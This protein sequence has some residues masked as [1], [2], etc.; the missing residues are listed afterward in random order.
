MENDSRG[1][2]TLDEDHF[3][4]LIP[5]CVE[6]AHAEDLPDAVRGRVAQQ[7]VAVVVGEDWGLFDPEQ[8][9]A[10]TSGMGLDNGIRAV[11]EDCEGDARYW[12]FE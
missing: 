11:Y 9:L 2:L 4:S 6:L 12:R 5:D 1:K 10:I 3:S 7:Q 8:N